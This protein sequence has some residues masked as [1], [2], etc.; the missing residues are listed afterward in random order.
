[1]REM[2]FHGKTLQTGE[3]V[4]GDLRHG[5]YYTG[6]TQ[7]YICVP[8]A[9]TIINYPVDPETVGQFVM[10]DKNCKE[11]YEGYICRARNEL[12]DGKE[13][14]YRVAWNENGFYFV[15][16]DGTP[17][18]HDNLNGIEVVG[19]IHDNPELWKVAE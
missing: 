10:W 15:D 13:G 5:G 12:H 6:D 18:H 4:A 16:G 9:G 3:W 19:N 17:W 14:L 11:V 8:F 2:K 1:M 7:T